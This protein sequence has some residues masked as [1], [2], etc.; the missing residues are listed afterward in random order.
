MSISGVMNNALSGML[1]SRTAA[2]TTAANIANA[3]TP[4]YKR[5]VTS[6]NAEETGG[7][8]AKVSGSASDG[9]N[10]VDLATEILDMKQAEI[11]FKANASVWEAGADMWD[12]LASMKRD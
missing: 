4:G 1:A 3:S 12:A 6:M 9:D 7:V 10:D 2:T 8:S 11:S 5:Q